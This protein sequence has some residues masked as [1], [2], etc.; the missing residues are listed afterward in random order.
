[1]LIAAPDHAAHQPVLTSCLRHTAT[2]TLSTRGL[3][4]PYRVVVRRHGGTGEG[5]TF[6][7]QITSLD[8]NMQSLSAPHRAVWL[9]SR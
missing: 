9:W 6:G 4:T 3:K 7:R 1:V 8:L 2:S 5:W